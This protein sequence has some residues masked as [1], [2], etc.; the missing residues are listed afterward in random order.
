MLLR[1]AIHHHC[2]TC[3]ADA[4]AICAVVDNEIGRVAGPAHRAWKAVMLQR[5]CD[6]IA[7]AADDEALEGARQS[8]AETHGALA[9]AL[10]G[11][12]AAA[13]AALDDRDEETVARGAAAAAAARNA[14]TTLAARVAEHRVALERDEAAAHAETHDALAG[15]ATAA[16]AAFDDRDGTTFCVSGEARGRDSAALGAALVGTRVCEFKLL[17]TC[18]RA[19]QRAAAAMYADAAN[20]EATTVVD[21]AT[22]S[23]TVDA[24]E[25]EEWE[26][27]ATD[28]VCL[29]GDGAI[30]VAAMVAA[31]AA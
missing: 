3:G 21:D 11:D 20:G 24:A 5:R 28:G 26:E 22:P 16:T 13:T 12:A 1:A 17:A 25:W 29:F 6:R 19:T 7:P 4:A 15:D 9:A 23:P 2:A 30:T 8:S 10:E 31:T 27:D 14:G 18:A